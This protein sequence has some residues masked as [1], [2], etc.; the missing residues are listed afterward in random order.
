MIVLN[1]SIGFHL[2]LG[3]AIINL[4]LKWPPWAWVDS[5]MEEVIYQVLMAAVYPTWVSG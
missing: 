4:Q 3:V 1:L 5:R 2:W